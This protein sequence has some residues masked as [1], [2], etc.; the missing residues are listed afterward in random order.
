M[1]NNVC[2][3]TFELHAGMQILT[4][5]HRLSHELVDVALRSLL[6]LDQVVSRFLQV[7][8]KHG[9]FRAIRV[10]SRRALTLTAQQKARLIEP[11]WSRVSLVA[12]ERGEQAESYFNATLQPVCCSGIGDDMVSR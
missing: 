9:P 8:S 6:A 2:G 3:A 12:G 5:E 7:K 10:R 4:V 11:I 1:F